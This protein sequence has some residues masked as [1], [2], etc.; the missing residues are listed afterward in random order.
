MVVR[1][2]NNRLA[3]GA[4][5]LNRKQVILI[6]RVSDCENVVCCILS[7]S[8][9]AKFSAV[10]LKGSWPD[11]VTNVAWTQTGN[12]QDTATIRR[13]EI[14]GNTL[15]LREMVLLAIEETRV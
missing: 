3:I 1:I 5:G 2:G 4:R 12:L 8:R 6:C 9:L 13:C 15:R 10:Y 7:V 11:P 14:N